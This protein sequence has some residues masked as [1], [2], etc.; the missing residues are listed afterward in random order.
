[1]SDPS[2]LF[3]FLKSRPKKSEC[4]EEEATTIK[5]ENHQRPLIIYTPTKTAVER[6]YKS[7]YIKTV[8]FLL[9][10]GREG[11]C[12]RNVC[13]SVRLSVYTIT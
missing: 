13:V 1:M 9:P 7:C 11:Y 12:H 3:S 4:E 5:S 8:I 10:L 6:I 2:N